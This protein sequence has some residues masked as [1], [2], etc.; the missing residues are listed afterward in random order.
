MQRCLQISSVSQSCNDHCLRHLAPQ[1]GPLQCCRTLNYRECG[2]NLRFPFISGLAKLTQLQL[3]LFDHRV[4]PGMLTG[5]RE[6]KE[7]S[8]EN[9]GSLP[10]LVIS[11]AAEVTRLVIG[12]VLVSQA[13]M[14][15]QYVLFGTRSYSI[16]I[17]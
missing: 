5:L 8:I 12:A 17:I 13:Y 14:Y 3:S 11:S 9:R 4:L 10:P 16:P 1:R 7:L 15:S 6:L 2:G